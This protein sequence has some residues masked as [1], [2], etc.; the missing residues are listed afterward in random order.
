M[1]FEKK[2]KRCKP[3]K[4]PHNVYMQVTYK[5]K[6]YERLKL[7]RSSL[8]W[9]GSSTVISD[10]PRGNGI[11]KPTETRAIKLANIDKE[12]EAIEKGAEEVRIEFGGKVFEKFD[13]LEAFWDYN[14]F[15]YMFITDDDE[16]DGP[17]RKTWNNF[18]NALCGKI[19]EKLNLF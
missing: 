11:S 19:A 12:I 2:R 9:V 18:K 15:R 5:I 7:E 17:C 10:M 8:L 16:D 3:Y 4:L 14:Y 1:Y 6:D 13:I